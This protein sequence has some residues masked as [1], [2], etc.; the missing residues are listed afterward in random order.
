MNWKVWGDDASVE[1]E[2]QWK[3]IVSI[4]IFWEKIFKSGDSDD[5][6]LED[7]TTA[8]FELKFV[9]DEEEMAFDGGEK[10]WGDFF[11]YTN[12]QNSMDWWR[13]WW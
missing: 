2:Q 9:K 3:T 8:E 13:F 5:E 7:F 10:M 11:F 12:N 6:L 4:P 1:W